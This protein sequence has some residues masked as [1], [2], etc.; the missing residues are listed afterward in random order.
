M[1]S[2]RALQRAVKIVGGQSALARQLGISQKAVNQM[3]KRRKVAAERVIQIA[4][5]AEYQVTPHQLRAD[6]YPYPTDA[7][8]PIARS[9][10]AAR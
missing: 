1:T 5:A 6:L 3:L 2:T 8:P 9:Q 4:R 10:I 7:L